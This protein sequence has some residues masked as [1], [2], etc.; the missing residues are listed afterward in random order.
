MTGTVGLNDRV[1]VAT[2]N[3]ALIT[4]TAIRIVAHHAGCS[5]LPVRVGFTALIREVEAVSYTHLTLPTIY[6]V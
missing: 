6:S 3:T 5:R 1:K 4:M 2:H